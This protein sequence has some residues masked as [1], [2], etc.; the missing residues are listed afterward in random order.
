MGVLKYSSLV[1][2]YMYFSAF[3]LGCDFNGV[4]FAI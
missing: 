1:D 2:Q 3:K 4:V